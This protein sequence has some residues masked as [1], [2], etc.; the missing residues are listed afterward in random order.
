MRPLI[1]DGGFY[2]FVVEI[3]GRVGMAMGESGLVGRLI[4]Y[5]STTPCIQAHSPF[6]IFVKDNIHGSHN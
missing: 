5:P 3:V 4:L 6:K 1:I 2:R